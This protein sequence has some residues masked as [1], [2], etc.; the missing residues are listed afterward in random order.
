MWTAIAMHMRKGLRK[1][2]WERTRESRSR[3]YRGSLMDTVTTTVGAGVSQET[4]GMK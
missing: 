2:T 1:L 4:S 3:Y